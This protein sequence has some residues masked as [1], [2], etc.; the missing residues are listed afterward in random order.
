[1]EQVSAARASD[2]LLQFELVQTHWTLV[3]V[4]SCEVNSRV[5]ELLTALLL[6]ATQIAAEQKADE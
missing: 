5:A 2:A 4:T 6:E 3:G 1:M